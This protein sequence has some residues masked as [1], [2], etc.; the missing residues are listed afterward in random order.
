M[1]G[2]AT[3]GWENF[4]V[5]EASAA[6][7]L[8][9]LLFVA[10]SINLPKIL[11]YRQLPGRAGEALI[12]LLAVL[13]AASL[14]LVP[15]Q[16]RAALGAEILL[17]GLFEW[18]YPMILQSRVGRL[19]GAPRRWVVTRVVTHQMATMPMVA[20]GISLLAGVGGGLYWLALA[21]VLSFAA[22]I[23][24]AWVLLVEIQR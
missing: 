16:S 13:V 5:A 11:A 8:A 18:V 3:A 6:A 1:S 14:G 21:V 24:H 20:T 23:A 19:P 15:G 4:F 10:I 12:I 17:V 2:Y 22:A 7:A 9:G